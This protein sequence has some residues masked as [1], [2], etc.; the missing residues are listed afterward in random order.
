MQY[1]TPHWVK[2]LDQVVFPFIFLFF[3]W[4]VTV[5]SFYYSFSFWFIIW[6]TFSKMELSGIF[7]WLI[8]DNHLQTSGV[9]L[10]HSGFPMYIRRLSCLRERQSS[11]DL[12]LAQLSQ[13]GLKTQQFLQHQDYSAILL[14]VSTHFDYIIRVCLSD[15]F[16]TSLLQHKFLKVK[17]IFWGIHWIFLM[18]T[19]LEVKFLCLWPWTTTTWHY[20]K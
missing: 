8:D 12:F 2:S 11:Q 5:L 1:P 15:F 13:Q 9:L 6:F 3:P 20:K 4:W 14:K 18:F 16:I 7:L 19:N 17:N 10:S